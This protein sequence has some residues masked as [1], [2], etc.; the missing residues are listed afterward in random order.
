MRLTFIPLFIIGLAAAVP[1]PTSNL[2]TNSTEGLDEIR[3]AKVS[4]ETGPFQYLFQAGQDCTVI[5]W[6]S[7]EKHHPA[8]R[9]IKSVEFFGNCACSVYV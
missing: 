2:A 9:P 1:M 3:C 6:W 8:P 5:D 4:F 7:Y